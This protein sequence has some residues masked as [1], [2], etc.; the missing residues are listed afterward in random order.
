MTL[1]VTTECSLYMSQ[2][3]ME[4]QCKFLV[5]FIYANYLLLSQHWNTRR[6]DRQSDSADMHGSPTVQVGQSIVGARLWWW[7]PKWVSSPTKP[8]GVLLAMSA[9]WPSDCPS[10]SIAYLSTARCSIDTVSYYRV[11]PVHVTHVHGAP[12]SVQHSWCVK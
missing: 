4:H 1:S 2:M 5:M 10:H 9:D 3:Y 6:T 11:L 7:D 8:E 12:V